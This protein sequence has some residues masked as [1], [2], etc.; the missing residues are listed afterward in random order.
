MSHF[1]AKGNVLIIS[2]VLI[3]V[4]TLI[5]ITS[6][7]DAAINQRI[8]ANFRD[9]NLSFQAAE[10]ALAEGEIRAQSL[11]GRHDWN[12][13]R[14]SCNGDDCYTATCNKGLCFNGSFPAANNCAPDPPTLDSALWNVTTTWNTADVAFTA[15]TNFPSLPV[16]PKYIIEFL[17][18]VPADPE[19]N[20]TPSTSYPSVDW[21]FMYRITGYSLGEG[22]SST[23]AVQSTFKVDPV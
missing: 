14:S 17:C 19:N 16:A 4:F 8:S 11:A 22:G 13:F 21:S 23:V 1:Y 18:F 12:D 3:L 7:D 6:I 20:P 10:A 15:T 5:G 2:L 9:S